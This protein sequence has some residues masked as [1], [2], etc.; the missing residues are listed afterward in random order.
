MTDFPESEWQKI[1]DEGMIID[2]KTRAIA[3]AG[4]ITFGFY[5]SGND[6]TRMMQ[7]SVP[8]FMSISRISFKL[9]GLAKKDSDEML[10]FYHTRPFKMKTFREDE[11]IPL[12]LLGSSWYDKRFD[13][14]RFCGEREIEPDMSSEILKDIPHH[15]IIG[16][17][18]VR[19][20]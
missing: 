8:G 15:Y 13:I 3:H 17:K 7:I 1:I 19:K 11:F 9:K 6:S 16:V 12:V 4:K 10:F 2:E 20:Q 5:P 18:F 14:F